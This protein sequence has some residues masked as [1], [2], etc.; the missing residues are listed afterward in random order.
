MKRGFLLTLSAVAAVVA[1]AA[2]A[3]ADPSAE[4]M[5]SMIAFSSDR[6]GRD[7]PDEIY[8]MNGDG[9]GETRVTV[10]TSGNSLFP[11]WSPNGKVIAFHNN[12]AELGGPEIFL[13]NADGTNQR[14]LTHDPLNDLAVAWSPR[15]N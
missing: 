6:P 2:S 8:V 15:H 11:E 7:A 4:G 10:T 13:I 9:T 1:F 12:P 3:G 5:G 14:R